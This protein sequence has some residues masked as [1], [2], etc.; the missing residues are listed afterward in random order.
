M[1]ACERQ[2]CKGLV[3]ER[4]GRRCLDDGDKKLSTNENETTG[5]C[6]TVVQVHVLDQ[7]DLK[8][9]LRTLSSGMPASSS[10]SKLI[11][12]GYTPPN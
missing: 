9:S 10:L 2:V 11:T 1:C 3:V 5:L 7:V 12:V 6:G 8:N 4:S